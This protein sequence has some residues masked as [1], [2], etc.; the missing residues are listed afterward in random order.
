MDFYKERKLMKTLISTI[1]LVA[2]TTTMASAA[3]DLDTFQSLTNFD[4]ACGSYTYDFDDAIDETGGSI[5]E[6]LAW[7]NDAGNCSTTVVMEAPVM[8]TSYADEVADVMESEGRAFF[9]NRNGATRVLAEVGSI[10]G[11]T[12]YEVR[13]VELVKQESKWVKR[14]RIENGQKV[15]VGPAME[16]TT[17]ITQRITWN[18]EKV[19]TLEAALTQL[20]DRGYALKD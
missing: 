4:D 5:P 16:T 3:V 7:V 9:E 1:A 2:T 8:T 10:E 6:I 15:L 18:G 12:V 20:S 17:K 19:H 14:Y 11:V 13:K